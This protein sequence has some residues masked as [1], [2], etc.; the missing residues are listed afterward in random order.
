MC[1]DVYAR[2]LLHV[3][4]WATAF[5]EFLIRAGKNQYGT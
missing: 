1:V 2:V 5:Y 4:E 3:A